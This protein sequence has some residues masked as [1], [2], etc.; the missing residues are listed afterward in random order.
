MPTPRPNVLLIVAD[1]FGVSQLGCSRLWESQPFFQTPHLDRLAAEGVRFARAYSTAPVCSPARASL[2]SG[3]HPARLQLTEFIP[4]SQVVN[5]PLLTPAWRRGLPTGVATLGTTLKACGYATAHFGKWHLAPD[6]NYAPGRAMDPES[7]GFDEVVV[8]R[9]PA[10]DADPE[11]DPHQIEALTNRA[12]DFCIRPHAGPFLCVL[13]H[14]ALHRPEIAPARLVAKYAAHPAADPAVNRPALGAMVE[15]MDAAVGRL[16]VALQQAG[17]DRD[18]LVIFTSDHG[19]LAPSARRKPLRGAK[20]DLYEGGLRVPLLLRYPRLARAGT[21]REAVVSTMD[22]FPTILAAC[23]ARPVA[24]AD[25]CELWPLV[26]D[27]ASLPPREAL[28]WHYPHYHHLGL[29]PCGAIRVG[30]YKLL[31]WFEPV[32]G[33]G[34]PGARPKWELF[35]VTADPGESRDLAVLEPSRCEELRRRLHAWRRAI[36]AQEM[37]RDPGYDPYV[38]TRIG[39]PPGDAPRPEL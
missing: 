7:H 13:A 12:I 16:L 31:E 27:A 14:N 11:A 37:V 28:C 29:G 20:A 36:G 8:T 6:D 17:R 21:I 5:A 10:A 15:Q 39:P 32:H 34:R 3:I 23:G 26:R 33:V 1:D 19:P 18:T 4:G 35:N 25:G 30:D 24:A 2:Y 9:K 38:A 22:L